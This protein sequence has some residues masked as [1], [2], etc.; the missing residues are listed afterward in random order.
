LELEVQE[1]EVGEQGVTDKNFASFSWFF[2]DGVFKV[3][4]AGFFIGW[5]FLEVLEHVSLPSLDGMILR[6]GSLSFKSLSTSLLWA[7]ERSTAVWA[8]PTMNSILI[9]VV[10]CWIFWVLSAPLAVTLEGWS[11]GIMGL[12]AVMVGGGASTAGVVIVSGFYVGIGRVLGG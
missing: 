6:V 10:Q 5:G 2:L 9:G 1:F 3:I 12:K 11:G 7:L 4:V 8:A